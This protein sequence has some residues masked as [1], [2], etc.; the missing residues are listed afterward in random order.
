M[1]NVAS[2]DGT[3]IDYTCQGA[4]PAVILVAGG[5][6][7]GS[8]NAPL[9]V[10]LS[11]DFT[12]YNYARR[13]TG[14][15]GDT[16]PWSMERELEDLDAVIALAGGS[17]H[18]YG[19]SAG[20][21]LALEAAAAGASITRLAVYEVPYNTADDAPQRQKAYF[22][23]LDALLADGRRGDALRLFMRTAG[24]SEEDIAG[25]AASPMWPALEDLAHTLSRG[26]GTLG[27]PPVA[28]LATITQ[29]TL[30]AIGGG[31]DPHTSGL[32]SDF[33]PR[34]ADA[35]TAS[36]PHA[37]QLVVEGQ[38]HMVDAKAMAPIL[39]SFFSG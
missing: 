20:G 22:D 26:F 17:A 25:A 31:Y 3:L 36:I 16:P 29:P 15:S 28:R 35:I 34:A 12:V 23:E 21:G 13:G 5:L 18:V 27:P 6:D 1:S 32:G 24:G 7:D 37:H 4:G 11:K 33:F 38:T 10:E 2:A 30:V 19:V 39:T 8:E 14:K 9:A